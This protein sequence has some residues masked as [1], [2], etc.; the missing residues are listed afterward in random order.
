VADRCL[1][2]VP[3]RDGEA[4]LCSLSEVHDGDHYLVRAAGGRVTPIPPDSEREARRAQ[5]AQRERQRAAA[6]LDAWFRVALMI[7]LSVWDIVNGARVVEEIARFVLDAAGSDLW[8]DHDAVM[9]LQQNSHYGATPEYVCSEFVP[10]DRGAP[11]HGTCGGCGARYAAHNADY[12]AWARDEIEKHHGV[13]PGPKC[14]CVQSSDT[15]HDP[16]CPRAAFARGA[17]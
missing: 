15:G 11:E 16:D 17:A 10:F 5:Y 7:K 4:W 2:E 6:A 9:K 1:Y 13:R 3:A 12:A 8:D 14:T